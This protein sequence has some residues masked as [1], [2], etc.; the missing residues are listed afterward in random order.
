MGT[1]PLGH[2][3]RE[4][5][6]LFLSVLG[7]SWLWAPLGVQLGAL[8]L[9]VMTSPLRPGWS[10]MMASQGLAP[11]SSWGWLGGLGTGVPACAHPHLSV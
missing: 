5:P 8:A 9:L 10:V 7:T 1:C 4:W 3:C 11:I 6:S 2:L